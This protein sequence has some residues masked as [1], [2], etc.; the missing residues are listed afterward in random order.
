MLSDMWVGFIALTLW[1]MTAAFLCGVV[2]SQQVRAWVEQ[3]MK[4]TP[5]DDAPVSEDQPQKDF[6]VASGRLPWNIRRRQLEK[7]FAEDQQEAV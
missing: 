4:T 2:Y 1:C 5:Q 3:R 7:Q 6:Q